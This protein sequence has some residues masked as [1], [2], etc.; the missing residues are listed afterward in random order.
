MRTATALVAAF[1]LGSPAWAQEQRRAR[2]VR[3]DVR[4]I[5]EESPEG[6][7][8][9]DY[10]EQPLPVEFRS[11]SPGLASS[12][13]Y[14][15]VCRPQEEDRT[16]VYLPLR[17][18]PPSTLPLS[19]SAAA[20]FPRI[21]VTATPQQ[22]HMITGNPRID[23]GTTTTPPPPPTGPTSTKPALFG[24]ADEDSRTS[25]D[26][27][28]LFGPDFDF[29]LASDLT[30]WASL[31]W[32]PEGTSL[33]LYARALFGSVEMFDTPTGVQL[34]GIGPRLTVPIAKAGSMELGVTLSA[35]P[36]FLHS[37]LGDAV[38]FDGGIGI[39]LEHFFTPTFSFIAAA[40]ANLYFSEN[41]SAFGPVVNLGFNLSW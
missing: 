41:V 29:V 8:D 5:I 20:G 40:E 7:Y 39:R 21:R 32:L 18:A 14:R 1:V 27:P 28:V 3:S 10:Y 23:P 9:H 19:V 34:Y 25:S 13:W 2:P 38:G 31:R 35:G 4:I 37:A 17:S 6:D 36:A 11:G 22:I 15:T 12:V 24:G 16:P 33:H 26:A 30:G